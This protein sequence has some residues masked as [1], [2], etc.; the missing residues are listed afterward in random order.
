MSRIVA[1]GGLHNARDLGG[2]SAGGTTTRFGRFY[3]APRLDDIGRDGFTQ[4]VE[5][6]VRTIVDLR[7][8]NEIG[9]LAL[10]DTVQRRHHPIEDQTDPTFMAAWGEHL[11]SPRYYADNLERWP[12]KIV[13]V[14]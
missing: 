9:P 13:E 6:G 12:A 14:F 4:M 11:S 3:R 1:W 7:N 2:I 8:A 5:A 10:P